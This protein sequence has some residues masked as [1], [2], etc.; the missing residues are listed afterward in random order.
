[1]LPLAGALLTMLIVGR[2]AYS[3]ALQRQAGEASV[4]L[5]QR[6]QVI[7]QHID[8]YRIMPAVLSLDPQLRATLANPA[9]R[10][11]RQR[12]NERLVQLNFAN[13]TSTLTLIDGNG[14]GL[15]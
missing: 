1:M 8:R 9:D 7:E 12:A 2:I 4:L 5:A 6:A 13:R 11:Q 15:A 14:I 10:V 3:Q